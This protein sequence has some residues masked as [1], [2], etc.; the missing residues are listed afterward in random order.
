MGRKITNNRSWVFE[1]GFFRV[2]VL[3]LFDD[4][5]GRHETP[6]G[7]RDRGDPAGASAPRRL[8]GT[9]AESEVP[10]V[11]INRPV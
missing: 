11:E 10:G 6:A 2:A 9:P 8:P 1:P 4:W 3:N 5:N 7:V